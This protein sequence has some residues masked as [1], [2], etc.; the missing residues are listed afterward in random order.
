[1]KDQANNRLL[2]VASRTRQVAFL[3]T[4]LV[5]LTEE[6]KL[7][8]RSDVREGRERPDLDYFI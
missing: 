3:S 7:K 8:R 1:V 6:R 4:S 2:T 5:S